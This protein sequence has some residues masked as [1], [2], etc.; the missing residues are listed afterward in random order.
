MSS[1]TSQKLAYKR[2]LLKLSGEALQGEDGFGILPEKLALISTEIARITQLGVQVALVVG[3]G[4]FMRGKDFN[5]TVMDRVTADQMGML[6]TIMN[7]LAIR[8]ALDRK[9]VA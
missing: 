6:A 7:A 2:I 5:D 9:S 3:A 8:D 1:Q 4:N